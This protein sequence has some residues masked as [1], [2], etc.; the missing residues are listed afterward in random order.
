[1]GAKI[2]KNGLKKSGKQNFLCKDCRKQ[3]LLNYKNNGSNPANKKLIIS[4][5]LRNCGVRDIE[6]I[7]KVSRKCV[8]N[9]LLNQAKKCE[10]IPKKEHYTSVQIDEHWSYVGHKKKKKRWLIYAYAP[11]TDEILAYEIGSRSEKTVRE[12]QKKMKNIKI[13]EICT[14]AWKSFEKV[15]QDENHKVGKEFTK[16]IEGV[17]NSLRIRNRRFVRK[18]TCF[19]KKEENHEASIKIMFAQRNYNYHTF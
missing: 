4:M 9:Q 19:S 16:N 10:I 11:E 7:L 5:L 13:D 3:F 17:N 2:V 8:L 15:F 14:D 1:M 12:L 6:T 18:T